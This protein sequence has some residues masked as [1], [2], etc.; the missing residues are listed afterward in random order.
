MLFLFFLRNFPGLIKLYIH[1]YELLEDPVDPEEVARSLSLPNILQ[2]LHN[3][4]ISI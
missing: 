2:Y 4:Y 3:F 1:L